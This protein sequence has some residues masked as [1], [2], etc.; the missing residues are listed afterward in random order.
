MRETCEMACTLY[1][2]RAVRTRETRAGA[3]ND[4]MLRGKS[5]GLLQA[6]FWS[7]NKTCPTQLAK[8]VYIQGPA[9]PLEL[10]NSHFLS[11]ILFFKF[12]SHKKINWPPVDP[13][14]TTRGIF[15]PSVV[16]GNY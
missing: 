13:V 3:P 7:E 10:R 12:E 6:S 5:V 4:F 14:F 16:D 9:L 8:S 2:R 15:L 1:A 11:F